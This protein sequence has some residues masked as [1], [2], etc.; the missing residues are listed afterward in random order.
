MALAVSRYSG[1]DIHDKSSSGRF[2]HM[3]AYNVLKDAPKFRSLTSPTN[4]CSCSLSGDQSNSENLDIVNPGEQEAAHVPSVKEQEDS[5]LNE[6]VAPA[7]LLRPLG[8][9][10]SKDKKKASQIYGLI[11]GGEAHANALKIIAIRMEETAK[12]RRSDELLSLSSEDMAFLDPED[13][14]R[15]KRV[16]AERAKRLIAQVED[17]YGI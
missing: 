5:D 12:K 3:A 16:R 10:S 14:E 4:W 8:R 15:T 1:Q 17:D 13:R 2:P 9:K 11:K 7:V 6:A